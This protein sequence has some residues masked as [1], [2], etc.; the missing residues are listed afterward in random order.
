MT[1]LLGYTDCWLV[2]SRRMIHTPGGSL[3]VE[4]TSQRLGDTLSRM[5]GKVIGGGH[6]YA[7]ANSYTDSPHPQPHSALSAEA[8]P[9]T[10]HY[11]GDE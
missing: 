10:P 7:S 9:Y 6:G 4:G 2:H 1:G 8:R 5:G 3:S 11:S